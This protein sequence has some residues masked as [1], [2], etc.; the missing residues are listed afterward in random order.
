MIAE[1]V[2]QWSE[3]QITKFTSQVDR[4]LA[5]SNR[6]TV[7]ASLENIKKMDAWLASRL[8][9]ESISVEQFDNTMIFV[10]LC[11]SRGVRET[12]T[13]Q[14]YQELAES[15]FGDYKNELL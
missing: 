14:K 10:S 6:D 8:D 9:N 4:A 5:F 2:E 1:E 15:R 11:N 12:L 13:S 7:Q 3:E